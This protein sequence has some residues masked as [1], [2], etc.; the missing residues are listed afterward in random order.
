MAE[1]DDSLGPWWSRAASDLQSLH[2]VQPI[3]RQDRRRSSACARGGFPPAGEDDHL[4]ISC[5][6]RNEGSTTR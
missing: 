5:Q 4:Q 1:I 6:P 2:R 3:L